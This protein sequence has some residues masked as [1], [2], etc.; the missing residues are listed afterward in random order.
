MSVEQEIIV[1]RAASEEVEEAAHGGAWKVAYADFMTA[2]MAFFLLMWILSTTEEKKLEGL[3]EYFTPTFTRSDGIGG[4]G[5]LAGTAPEREGILA[6]RMQDVPTGD[7]DPIEAP[8]GTAPNPW[9]DIEVSAEATEADLPP[10]QV[11]RPLYLPGWDSEPAFAERQNGGPGEATGLAALEQAAETLQDAL[12]T[13]PALRDIAGSLEMEIRAGG[14]D[15]RILDRD[16]LPMFPLGRAAF[17]EDIAAL[18][19]R[20]GASVANLPNRI[21]IT[22]HTDATPFAG[23]GSYGNWEL[24][25]DRAHATRRA[26]IAAGV[27]PERFAEVAGAADREP[28]R[29]ADPFHPSNRRIS[30][31]LLAEPAAAE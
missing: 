10:T 17:S 9:A 29:P 21:V 27:A 19:A 22:G 26:L 13:D 30:V 1:I 2:L 3:A 18:L 28:L 23:D 31:R 4:Q 11:P 14:L 24:S 6:N 20:V 15:L 5:A 7:N 25:T 16:D 8:P 12:D